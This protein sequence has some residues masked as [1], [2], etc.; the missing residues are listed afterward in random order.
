M[1][2]LPG[3][4]VGRGG[5]ERVL[6]LD[7]G[8]EIGRDEARPLV[9][10]LVER[11]LTV[12][13]RLAPDDGP[14]GVVGD[15]VAVAVD[16]LAV[17]LHVPLLEVGGEAVKVLV[18]RED[19]VRLGAEEVHVPD[20]EERHDHR[21]VPLGRRSLEVLIHRV[22]AI[23]QLLEAGHPDDAGDRQ[24]DR[25]P[26]RV[27]AA[28]PVPEREHVGDV[29]AE[30]AHLFLRRRDRDEVLRYRRVAAELRRDPCACRARVHQC[31]LRGQELPSTR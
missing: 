3:L 24:A 1:V 2:I 27:A 29:D 12:R 15:G 25:R 28:D 8:E 5:D 21:Q 20:A 7:G 31:L 10:E 17:A 23:E 6:R 16:A 14:G 19:G 11:V 30:R 26:E 22:R 18:V 9:N 13:P 4:A